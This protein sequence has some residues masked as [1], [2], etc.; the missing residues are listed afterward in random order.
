MYKIQDELKILL[1]TALLL[2]SGNVY[3]QRVSVQPIRGEISRIADTTHI[4]FFGRNEWVYSSPK[5]IDEGVTFTVPPFDQKTELSFRSWTCDHIKEIKIDKSAPDGNYALT[6]VLKNSNVE[7]FDYLTDEPSRLIVDFFKKEPEVQSIAAS[8]PAPQK[9]KNKEKQ[10]ADRRPAN[11]ARTEYTRLTRDPA[12]EILSTDLSLPPSS[13][14]FPQVGIFDA[15]DP[16]YRRFLIR[17]Y[18]I[19]EQSIIA[20][21]Q[22]IYIQF[23]ILKMPMRRFHDLMKVAPEYEVTAKEGR[24]NQEARLVLELSKTDRDAAF[25]SAYTYFIKE[26]PNSDYNEIIRNLAAEHFVQKY[27]KDGQLTDLRTFQSEYR[28]LITR[29]PESPLTPRNRLLLAYSSVA[30]GNGAEGLREL[31]AY[32][33]RYPDSSERDWIMLGI[34]E[35]YLLLNQPESAIKIYKDLEK[36]FRDQERGVEAAYRLGDVYLLNQNYK[37]AKESYETALKKYPEYRNV[38]PSL[39]YNLAESNFWLGNYKESLEQFVDHVQLFPD[40]EHGGYSLTRIGETLQILGAQPGHYSGAFMESYFRYPASPGSEVARVRMLSESLVDMKPEE[41]AQALR[42]IDKIS[43]E[44]KLPRMQEFIALTVSDGLAERGRYQDSKRRLIAYYQNNPTTS[45]LE[46]FRPRI[47]RNISDILKEKNE[48]EEYM[49]ALDFHSKYTRTWLRNTDRIDIPYHRAYAFERSGVFAP[50]E[51]EYNKIKKRISKIKGT[52]EF[53]EREVY[54]HLPSIDELNLRLAAT[55]LGQRKYREALSHLNEIKGSFAGKNAVERVQIGASIAENVGNIAQAIRYLNELVSGW[56]D[57]PSYLI[58][59]RLKLAELYLGQSRLDE[60]K[61]QIDEIEKL[62]GQ[63]LLKDDSLLKALN[64]KGDYFLKAGK[65][66]EAVDAYLSLLEEFEGKKPVA[67]IRYKAGEILFEDGDLRGAERLWSQID[68]S[69]ASFYKGLA[70]EKLS[71][72]DWEDNYQR[73]IERIPAAR[74][75]SQ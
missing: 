14:D 32:N 20:S 68:E 16:S 42:E 52:P 11:E 41:E 18:Q 2:F 26:Y 64:L 10:K 44:S 73:Y 57:K 66:K 3:A 4:E 75:L 62:K 40:H 43:N 24:E 39:T 72:A 54:E 31:M 47:E 8:T 21:R 46:V 58:E 67:S 25:L 51:S 56:K 27:L 15:A 70:K 48:N 38:F 19:S 30:H 49:K 59:P 34:A 65:N 1:V 17:D 74:E 36:N 33:E 35:S 55:S 69:S 50:A 53:Q 71:Q 9:P 28:Y 13:G 12:S 45:D 23:P 63:N 7:S 6:F 61:K 60:T 22:N 5:S 37:K 29:Y